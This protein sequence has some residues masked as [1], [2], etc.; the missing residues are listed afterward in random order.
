MND[1]FKR[2]LVVS[3]VDANS[4][5]YIQW[6]EKSSDPMK[7]VLSSAAIPFVFPDQDWDGGKTVAIDGGSAWNTN[8][9]SSIKRCREQVDDDSQITIDVVSCF[10]HDE[11]VKYKKDGNTIHNFLR[12]KDIKDYYSGM[13]DILEFQRA[14]PDVNYRYYV[15]PSKPLPTLKMLDVMNKTSTYPMQM[16]G[17]LDGENA[18]KSGEGFIFDQLK[19]YDLKS[20]QRSADFVSKIIKDQAQ[21]LEEKQSEVPI[22]E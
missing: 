10:A 11:S 12:Y 16:Q 7:G 2:K 5:N 13:D 21:A 15:A 19:D 1:T 6:D 8:L 18:I 17:R 3:S 9:V 4:G 20:K 22:A 14:F